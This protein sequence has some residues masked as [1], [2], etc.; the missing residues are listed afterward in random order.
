LK[1]YEVL[2][3]VVACLKRQASLFVAGLDFQ[4]SESMVS[5]N[6]TASG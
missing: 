3:L 6:A 4:P 1:S 5:R 2:F